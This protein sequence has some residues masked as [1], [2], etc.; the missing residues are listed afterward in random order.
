M[1]SLDKQKE[2]EQIQVRENGHGV[3][4]G[5]SC[6]CVMERNDMMMTGWKRPS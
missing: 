1:K 2:V 5:L 6:S 4:N 3:V